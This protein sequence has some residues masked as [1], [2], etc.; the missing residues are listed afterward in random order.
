[1]IYIVDSYAWVE[2][3]IGSEKGEVLRKILK[4]SGNKLLTPECCVAELTGWALKNSQDFDKVFAAIRANSEIMT[5]TLHDWI[6]AGRIRF[7]IRKKIENF[8]LIDS[9]ILAKQREFNALVVS[10]DRHF[11]NLPNVTFMQ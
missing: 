8:G 1:M 4:D 2:Y 9:V 5:V 7:E 10:G 3:F 6:E 11:T